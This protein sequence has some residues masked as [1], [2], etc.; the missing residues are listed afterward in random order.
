MKKLGHLL[1][2]DNNQKIEK[3]MISLHFVIFFQIIRHFHCSII[4]IFVD[5]YVIVFLE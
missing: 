2:K 4:N 3:A 5:F 1:F